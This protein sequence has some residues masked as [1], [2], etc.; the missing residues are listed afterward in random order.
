MV[1]SLS[2]KTWSPLEI[3]KVDIA[4]LL[5]HPVEYLLKDIH[6]KFISHCS[7]PNDVTIVDNDDED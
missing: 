7:S 1:T 5:G 3:K 6:C 4:F 2:R